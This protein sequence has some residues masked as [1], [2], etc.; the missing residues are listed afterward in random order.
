M[1]FEPSL[2]AP[3]GL[4]DGL[5]LKEMRYATAVSRFA[6]GRRSGPWFPRSLP[7][8]GRDS[9]MTYEAPSTVTS[10]AAAESSAAPVAAAIESV[11]IVTRRVSSPSAIDS[12]G[13]STT[14]SP[15]GRTI[16]PRLRASSAT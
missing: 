11:V 5:A 2:S 7:S 1:K 8:G 16:A 4:A 14:T 6:P 3:T 10:Q 12:G 9:A 15:S 13:M